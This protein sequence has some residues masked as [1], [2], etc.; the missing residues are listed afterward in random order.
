MTSRFPS[1]TAIFHIWTPLL[2]IRNGFKCPI[3]GLW[4]CQTLDKSSTKLVAKYRL[5]LHRGAP[6]QLSALP[7]PQHTVTH[8]SVK[9]SL[10]NQT[11][12]ILHKGSVKSELSCFYLLQTNQ[13]PPIH[14]S[15]LCLET[16][17]SELCAQ[18][19]CG[20]H[21]AEVNWARKGSV[22]NQHSFVVV[23]AEHGEISDWGRGQELPSLI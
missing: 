17:W 15:V 19:R 18:S 12:F 14:H 11:V 4:L 6:S 10:L 2:I 16:M 20:R 3:L 13:L 1:N 5:F 7:F 21:E 23:H 9:S 8:S 22:L